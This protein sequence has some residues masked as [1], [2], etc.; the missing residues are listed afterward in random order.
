MSSKK[1][2]PYL[3]CMLVNI[4]FWFEIC[5]LTE[6]SLLY[7]ILIIIRS[8]MFGAWVEVLF[9]TANVT[10]RCR[11]FSVYRLVYLILVC[12][13]QDAWCSLQLHYY[14][15]T[16]QIQTVLNKLAKASYVFRHIWTQ[17]F[18]PVNALSDTF[19]PTAV[20]T[21]LLDLIRLFLSCQCCFV[22][23]L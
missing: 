1:P 4:Y 2:F 10:F 11:S 7:T 22:S 19:S 5:Q 6:A 20:L 17:M 3:C 21:H 8:G 18:L 14:N 12:P 9:S 15:I 13:T 23:C 16:L